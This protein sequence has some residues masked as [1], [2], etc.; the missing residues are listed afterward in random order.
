MN[1]LSI[2]GNGPVKPETV[3]LVQVMTR[4]GDGGIP[5][6]RRPG[7]NTSSPDPIGWAGCSR[8]TNCAGA[9]LQATDD[10]TQVHVP[11]A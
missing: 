4:G 5:P 9:T 11:V 6:S 7:W 8:H 3:E 2:P 1:F 10:K